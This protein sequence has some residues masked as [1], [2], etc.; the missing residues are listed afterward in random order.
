ME[1]GSSDSSFAER[2][3]RA[4]RFLIYL[5]NG[6]RAYHQHKENMA[7]LGTALLVSAFGGA[8]LSSNWPPLWTRSSLLRFVLPLIVLGITWVLFMIYLVWQ[9]RRRRWAAIRLAATEHVLAS[10]SCRAP[11][12]DALQPT[13]PD[14]QQNTECCFRQCIWP[15]RSMPVTRD[16]IMRELPRAFV[17]ALTETARTGSPAIIHERLLLVLSW[18][19]FVSL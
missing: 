7:Y 15:S 16:A 8:L 5:A 19:L 14:E 12:P 18:L 11:S 2:F 13:T 9:L 1:P 4:E 17:E 10:W 6:D 3:Q